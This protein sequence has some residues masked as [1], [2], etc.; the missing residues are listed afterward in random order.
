MNFKAYGEYIVIEVDEKLNQTAGGLIL[1]D[2]NVGPKTTGVIRSVG[3]LVNAG[4]QTLTEY[5]DVTYVDEYQVGDRVLF[6]Y[7]GAHATPLERFLVV[8]SSSVLAKIE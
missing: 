8:K 7:N 2:T 6:T 4:V 3:S 1:A 5:A